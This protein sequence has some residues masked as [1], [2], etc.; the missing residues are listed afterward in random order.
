MKKGFYFLFVVFIT[1]ILITTDIFAATLGWQNVG[2][3]GFSTGQVENLSLAMDGNAPYVVYKDQSNANKATAMQ[4]NGDNW[5]VVGTVGFSAGEVKQ[6]S[7]A[8]AGSTPYVAYIDVAN[9]SKATVMRFKNGISWET[10]GTPGFSTGQITYLSFAL[11][12]SMPYVAYRDLSNGFKATVMKFDGANWV[13]VGTVGFSDGVVSSTSLALDGST[14]YVAFSDE[15][16]SG[17]ATVMRYNGS[18]WE[19]VGSP[20]FSAGIAGSIKLALDGSTPYVVFRDGSDSYKATVMRFDGTNWQNVG[21]AGF[22]TGTVFDP[23]L[24]LDGSMPYVAFQDVDTSKEATAMRFNGTSWEVV[25]TAGFSEGGVGQVNLALHGSTPFVA[26]RDWVNGYKATVMKYDML[27]S[28]TSTSPANGATFTSTDTLTINFDRNMLHDGSEHAANKLENYLLVEAN[29]DGFQTETCAVGVGGNDIEI[30]ILSADYD[31]NSDTGPYQAT[32][33]VDT[34]E[35]GEYKLLV[36]GSASIHDT[37]SNV[38][39]GGTDT[40]VVFTITTAE[41]DDEVDVLPQ[42][43]FAPGVITKI[44]SQ[45]ASEVFQLYNHVSLEIPALSL[46]AP[47][48]GVPFSQGGWNLTWLGNQAGWLHGTVFPSWAGNS[49]ITA[50]VVDADGNPGLFSDLNELKWGEEVIVHAF[51]QDYVYEVREIEKYVQPDDTSY[52]FEHEDYPYLT[53]ITCKG[54]DEDSDSYRWRV[55]VKAVQTVIR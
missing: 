9:G 46:D 33:T 29:E 54:Y 49:V 53:L 22:S 2:D 35:V 50:H 5:E 36:C 8:L 15:T 6:T 10:V 44:P 38:I 48:V 3:P 24:A 40:V 27:P 18:I 26:F 47:I 32:L 52:V 16:K 39:N 37:S 43:G 14:P 45:S 20:G 11:G 12:N 19:K 55:V 30:P 51:G 4:Y 23:S 28:V 17:K 13:V 25:G 21:S 34:L 31:N 1:A 7:I 41:A 42:T